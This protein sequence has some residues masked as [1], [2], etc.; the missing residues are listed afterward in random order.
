MRKVE[1]TTRFEKDFKKVVRQG[2][3]TDSIKRIIGL[4][5]EGKPLPVKNKDHKL[6]GNYQG[7]RECH[8]SPDWLLIY[9]IDGDIVSLERTGSHSDLFDK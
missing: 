8:I 5:Q 3:N 6:K 9:R 2:K 1:T 4:L 7:Y